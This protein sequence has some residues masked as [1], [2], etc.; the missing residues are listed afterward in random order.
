MVTFNEAKE[1]ALKL[2]PG[3]DMCTETNDAFMFYKKDDMPRDGGH[4][5]CV[6]MKEPGKPVSMSVYYTDKM[7]TGEEVI[8][9]RDFDI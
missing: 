6:I 9:I 5:D 2:E 8:E 1:I 4:G 3:V 7:A